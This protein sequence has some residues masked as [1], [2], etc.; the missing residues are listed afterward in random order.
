MQVKGHFFL[1]TRS[2][3]ISAVFLILQFYDF[4]FFLNRRMCKTEVVFISG[5]DKLCVV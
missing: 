5:N 4:E 3:I 1:C 2:G